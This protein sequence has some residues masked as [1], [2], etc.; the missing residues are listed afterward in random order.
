M[1]QT[2]FREELEKLINREGLEGESD[3]PDFILADYLV[4][5]LTAF[6]KAVNQRAGWYHHTPKGEERAT[7]SM[8]SVPLMYVKGGYN[9]NDK[10]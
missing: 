6:D 7:K 8:A 10:C 4:D 3:T 1:S 2:E 9:N 5:C